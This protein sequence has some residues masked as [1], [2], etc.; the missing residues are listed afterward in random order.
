MADDP[1]YFVITTGPGGESAEYVSQHPLDAALYIL[2]ADRQGRSSQ[3][4][5]VDDDRARTASL[6]ELATPPPVNGFVAEMWRNAQAYWLRYHLDAPDS[7]ESPGEPDTQRAAAR[8]AAAFRTPLPDGI[9]KH[10]ELTYLSD[11]DWKRLRTGVDRLLPLLK[12]EKQWRAPDRVSL[13]EWSAQDYQQ[14]WRQLNQAAT[15]AP[16]L[17]T[18]ADFFL[19]MALDRDTRAGRIA[20][21][22]GQGHPGLE[23]W[24]RVAYLYA[25]EDV[26][27][28]ERLY[29]IYRDFPAGED[30]E[31]ADRLYDAYANSA[32]GI[33]EATRLYARFTPDGD[34]L[35]EEERAWAAR[36]PREQGAARSRDYTPDSEEAQRAYWQSSHSYW[37]AFEERETAQYAAFAFLAEHHEEISARAPAGASEG[38]VAQARRLLRAAFPSEQQARLDVARQLG[39]L[40]ALLDVPDAPDQSYE[41]GRHGR[42]WMALGRVEEALRAL[43][44]NQP[45]PDEEPEVTP[46]PAPPLLRIGPEGGPYAV[47]A[48]PRKA[49]SVWTQRH[50]PGPDTLFPANPARIEESEADGRWRVRTPRSLVEQARVAASGPREHWEVDRQLAQ[51]LLAD[52]PEGGLHPEEMG[53][54]WGRYLGEVPPRGPVLAW[55]LRLT[56]DNPRIPARIQ[57]GAAE[58]R[59]VIDW[60]LDFTHQRRAVYRPASELEEAASLAT[61]DDGEIE[62]FYPGPAGDELGPRPAPAP[63]ATILA[64]ATI[65]ETRYTHAEFTRPP[66]RA[67]IVHSDDGFPSPYQLIDSRLTDTNVLFERLASPEGRALAAAKGTGEAQ[68]AALETAGRAWDAARLAEQR[69]DL[70]LELYELDEQTQTGE[71]DATAYAQQAGRVWDELIPLLEGRGPF[72]AGCL[73]R[74]Y[75]VRVAGDDT[76]WGTLTADP[77]EAVVQWAQHDRPVQQYV[78]LTG[79]TGSLKTT[80]LPVGRLLTQ[81]MREAG[82]GQG[83]QE[84][85]LGHALAD[86]LDRARRSVAAHTEDGQDPAAWRQAGW[87]WRV[88]VGENMPPQ[89]TSRL[90]PAA[91]REVAGGDLEMLRA[92]RAPGMEATGSPESRQALDAHFRVLAA[93]SVEIEQARPYARAALD[94]LISVDQVAPGDGQQGLQQDAARL[95]FLSK[96]LGR[97]N[98]M[99]AFKQVADPTHGPQAN[100][101]TL[102]ALPQRLR[103]RP[104][105]AKE[106][107]RAAER[108]VGRQVLESLYVG[109]P[110]VVREDRAFAAHDASEAVL[111]QAAAEA[112][113]GLTASRTHELLARYALGQTAPTVLPPARPGQDLDAAQRAALPPASTQ[114]PTYRASP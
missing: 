28:A 24:A 79:T 60:A 8:W 34:P 78:V 113:R 11:R 80:E 68:R 27:A 105:S 14:A 58:E 47:T 77:L 19:G 2:R 85:R 101:S 42:V 10:S 89:V 100:D 109:Y 40:D 102:G 6:A 50:R 94:H 57:Q 17:R 36:W 52:E 65:G 55:V 88:R 49:L 107:L 98:L 112:T 5:A 25:P 44:W 38:V 37:T 61:M 4:L 67:V 31:E 22:L 26:A 103:E 66:R 93:A 54:R 72:E 43:T 69:S 9:A 21:F 23:Q 39:A 29:A 90:E 56:G 51:W 62:E 82:N 20:G 3:V 30:F 48:D 12:H 74:W 15:R 18:T 111:L 114:A 41:L 1:I 33:E 96:E 13:P 59:A 110:N 73:R 71:L 106:L 86:W 7:L 32:P 76:A 64:S 81:A 84:A 95:W 92:I 83:A 16:A 87:A 70:Q 104:E 97:G 53:S 35:N 108:A 99:D 46:V 63:R 75:S 45:E 91:A